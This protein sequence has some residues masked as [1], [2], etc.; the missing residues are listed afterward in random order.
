M[1]RKISK[2]QLPALERLSKIIDYKTGTEITDLFRKAGYE[3]IK[4]DGGTK[5]RFLDQTFNEKNDFT[6]EDLIY[7]KYGLEKNIV[8]IVISHST[9]NKHDAENIS[10]IL[11]D[12][13]AWIEVFIALE[14]LQPAQK[15]EEDIIYNLNIC[16]L[17]RSISVKKHCRFKLCAIKTSIH[18]EKSHRIFLIF[19]ASCLFSVE[20]DISQ[21]YPNHISN[22]SNLLP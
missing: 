20:C 19:S 2:F 1:V 5:W 11:C 18:G 3:D 4:H 12:F 13:S 9:E 17:F 6:E 14:D 21:Q 16:G 10:T 15:F 7:L 22:E 8:E